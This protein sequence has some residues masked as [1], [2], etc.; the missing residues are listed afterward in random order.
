MM[1]APDMTLQKL[2]KTQ[3]GAPMDLASALPI[4]IDVLRGLAFLDDAGIATGSCHGRALLDRVESMCYVFDD[5]DPQL[6][7]SACRDAS[8]PSVF[9]ESKFGISATLQAPEVEHGCPTG[10]TDHAWTAALMLAMMRMGR[11]PVE[12]LVEGS[13]QDHVAFAVHDMLSDGRDDIRDL[14]RDDFEIEED[15]G[16]ASL[17][18][19]EQSLLKGMLNK[20]APK[21]WTAKQALA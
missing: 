18:P 7:C 6:T 1:E 9:E 10:P 21:R 17:D 20:D 3:Q 16:F 13:F 12:R 4:F 11:N 5:R 15:P 8:T 14:I 2:L 19:G